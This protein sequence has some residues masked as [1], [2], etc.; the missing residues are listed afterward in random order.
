MKKR[1]VYTTIFAGLLISHNAWAID[2]RLITSPDGAPVFQLR[3]FD[4]G[5]GPSMDGDGGDPPLISTWTLSRQQKSATQ[6]A[7]QYWAELIKPALGQLPI[8]INVGTYD[9]I[10]AAGYSNDK[11]SGTTS[12]T[13]IQAALLG[14]DPGPMAYGAHAYFSMG[15]LAFDQMDYAPSQLAQSP[16][17]V[18]TYAVAFH[19][20]AH[21][22]GVGSSAINVD[23]WSYKPQFTP[24]LN[25][26]TQHL[27]DDN[28]NPA[29]GGQAILCN[30]YG[31]ANDYDPAAFDLR[32]DKGYFAGRHVDEVLKGVMPGVPV[33]ILSEAGPFVDNNF[34]SHLELTNSLMSHQPYR[35]YTTFMEAELAVMQDLG[36]SIDRRNFYGHSV[37][38]DGQTLFNRH[39][40]FKRNPQGTAYLPGQY[41]TATLGMGLHIYGNGN[42]VYQQADLLTVGAGGA[43]IRVDGQANTVVVD[44]GTRIHANGINGN[45]V[46]FAYGKNHK[47]VQRGEVQALGPNGVAV[48]FDFGNNIMGNR[49]DFGNYRGSYIHLDENGDPLPLRDELQGALV[50]QFDLTGRLAGKAAAILISSNALVNRI[51][52][53]RG[54]RIEGDIRSDYAEVDGMGQP[55][56]TQL[57]FGLL[58]N[59]DGRATTTPDELFSFIY[60]GNIQ[61]ANL[62]VTTKGGYTS[63]NGDHTIHSMTV[64]ENSSLGG[65]SRYTLAASQAFVNNGIVAPGNSLGAITIDGDYRQSPGGTLLME[66]DGRGAHDT[67]AVT[68]DAQLNGSLALAPLS[69]WYA[70]GW[71]FTFDDLLQAGTLTGNFSSVDT[72]IDS[73]TL[74]FQVA[75]L[76]GNRYQVAALRPANAYSRYAVDGNAARTGR[77]LDT[78]VAD[79]QED[80]QPLYQSLDFSSPD[81][82]EVARALTQLSPAAY[83]AMLANSLARER[84]I[85][86][87]LDGR[88]PLN[89]HTAQEAWTTFALP[90]GGGAWQDSRGSMV[91]YDASSYGIVF[92]TEKHSAAH[93]GLVLGMHGA[94]SGQSVK[95]RSPYNGSGKSTAFSLGLHARYE[96]DPA[97]GPYA[98]GQGRIGIEEGQMDRQVAFANYAATHK[99]DWTGLNATLT[100]GGGYRWPIADGISAGPLAALNYA[101]VTRPDITESGPN[102]SRLALDS[103]RFDSLRSSIG[104][105]A[106]M[107]LSQSG[108]DKLEA[109]LQVSWDHELLDVHQEQRAYFAGYRHAGFNNRQDV[110]S[111]DALRAQLGLQYQRDAGFAIGGNVSTQAFR[112]GYRS[113][114]GN[115]SLLWRY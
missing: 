37:Y 47:L 23:N 82:N 16:T 94:V 41:N 106:S 95:I 92:G 34:M 86:D 18:D 65:N 11:I 13:A 101:T 110:V 4:Q 40:Y 98:F 33:R 58:A 46:M 61:G 96:P 93:S 81:G 15:K 103:A 72:Q 73:P 6:A 42:T 54:A 91:P 35:N 99:S 50:D 111:R 107:D 25:T 68:G 112:S 62:A 44:P 104:L 2:E 109:S 26:Y 5:E 85:G 100:A 102:A 9:V 76:P 29:R 39:G 45:G 7:I 56:L 31:C 53:M 105:A 17:M 24:I 97:R 27:R 90:F 67:L 19:E 36:Y 8:P 49:F 32:Q 59:Q 1:H 80:I 43:G 57:S 10:N 84:Q 66:V 79:A 60:R 83:S 114:S 75:A 71:Q 64:G 12:L 74:S 3:F 78:L 20:L 51:N 48:R 22:L 14:Q 108:K 21:G 88:H 55:R 115:L 87:I 113:V 30:G 52:V 28:G 70:P 89:D 69:D 38:G 63:L 77:A